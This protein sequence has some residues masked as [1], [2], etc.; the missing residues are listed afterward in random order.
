MRNLFG[1]LL[2]SVFSF[3]LC[4]AE[5]DSVPEKSE[6]LWAY[7]LMQ[8]K[9]LNDTI[10]LS[11]IDA[12]QLYAERWDTLAHPLVLETNYAPFSRFVLDKYC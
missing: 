11:I 2:F 10:Y 12:A 4:A 5:P 6:N 8:M 9:K 1:I 3:T 7:E